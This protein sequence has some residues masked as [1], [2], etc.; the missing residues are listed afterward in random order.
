MKLKNKLV[1][2]VLSAVLLTGSVG[3]TTVLTNVTAAAATTVKKLPA[4]TGIKA[5]KTTDS[6]TLTWN[7]VKGADAYRVYKYNSK[8]KKYVKYKDVTKTTCK[9]TGLSAS[10]TY[11]FKVKALVYTEQTSSDVISVKTKAEEKI[12]TGG[13]IKVNGSTIQLPAM[14]ME[15]KTYEWADKGEV[16]YHYATS[17][18]TGMNCKVDGDKLVLS[19]TGEKTYA[20]NRFHKGIVGW[21]LYEV[22]ADGEKEVANGWCD[23]LT[24][25]SGDKFEKVP[26]TIDN[27]LEKGKN[28]RIEFVDAYMW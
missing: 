26:Y 24:Q 3:A 27:C 17:T 19:F 5:T 4:P 15:V 9:I 21:K 12:P 28:Y 10:K 1:S 8:T 23:T 16:W 7:A 2:A 6:I 18:V 14:P 13:E 22:A 20:Y 25:D 11:K